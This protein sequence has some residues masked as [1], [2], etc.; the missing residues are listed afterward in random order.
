MPPFTVNPHRVD[1]YK[2]FKFRVTWEGRVVAGVSWVGPLRRT[3]ETIE[4]RTGAEPSLSRRMPGLTKFAPVALR[5]GVTHDTEFERWASKVWRLGAGL[6]TEASLADF[7]RDVRLDLLNEAGQ[8]AL[9][10]VLFRCWPSEYV[11]LPELDAN[12]GGVAIQS[13]TLQTE[14]WERD[15][16]VTEPVEPSLE[17]EPAHARGK[18]ERKG[19][20]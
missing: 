5:R 9:A 1:P 11:A 18:G 2:S 14:G 17:D 8:V 20:A 16:S 13:V 4:H 3:T 19:A 12:G 7:R 15:L 6:G 10:Y